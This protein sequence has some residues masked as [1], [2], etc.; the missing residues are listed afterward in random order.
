MNAWL[1]R[2]EPHTLLIHV[3]S[4]AST[5]SGQRRVITD[6]I[7]KRRLELAE[8]RAAVAVVT[9]SRTTR[10]AA[11]AAYWLAPPPYE[12]AVFADLEPAQRW[13]RRQLA[14]AR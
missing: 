8:F 13:V 4:G 12:V 11:N 10:A 6:W 3:K 5:T 2:R 7:R 1:D 9:G 14:P